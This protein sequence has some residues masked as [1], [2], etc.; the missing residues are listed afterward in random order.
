MGGPL[1][2][3]ALKAAAIMAPLLLQQ[4]A[5]VPKYRANAAH[6]QRRLDLWDKGS[7]G[8]LLKEGETIQGQLARSHK[9]LDDTALAKRFATMV[10]NNNFKGAMSLVTEK[11]KGGVLALTESTKKEMSAKHPKPAPIHP[12]ALITGDVPPTVHPVFYDAIDGD[13]IRR[14][15]IR[16]SGGAGASQQEDSL[17][18][19]MTTAFKDSSAGLCQ[20][21]ADFAR[22]LS[23]A[24]VDPASLAAL[25]ANRGIAIDK[26]PG[27]RPVGV[28][29]ILRRIIG[30]AVMA[31]NGAKV[32]EAA[33]SLQLCAGQ[34]VGVESAIHAMRSFFDQDDSD[35]ILLIDADNAFNRVNRAVALWNIQYTCPVMKHVLVN[36]YRTASRIF[37]NGD[38]TSYELLSQEGTTQGC[39]LAMAMYALSLV[40]LLKQL[41]M[42]RQ[43]WYAD[44]ATG[45]DSFVKLRSWFDTLLQKGPLY[46]YYPKPS[47]CILLTRPDRVSEANALFNGSGIKASADGSKDSGIEITT[48]GT[49]HLG[50]VLGTSEFKE[51]YVKKKMDGWVRA[52]RKMR[53]PLLSRMRCLLLSL[54]F[55]KASGPRCPKQCQESL[56]ISSHLRTPSV[57]C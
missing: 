22:R 36:F 40:P 35:G 50:A 32:Q 5:G 25:L 47:K 54:M 15:A 55:Y 49:R 28:G 2:C 23:T 38:Q 14:C 8:D 11:G 45:C 42:C 6:L 7:F 19:K 13:L 37:M 18:H 33:G 51:E 27:L 34:P 1:Q 9:T 24:Y 26:C 12:E 44:D 41:R 20:A 56:L 16:T 52:V 46:G 57:S 43:V 31:V 53:S 21:V 17:W 4:P 30:K 39:P 29:E 3:I 48:S 10:F